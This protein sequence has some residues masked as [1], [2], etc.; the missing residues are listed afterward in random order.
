MYNVPLSSCILAD[1]FFIAGI[2]AGCL[3][4]IAMITLV[5]MVVKSKKAA[6]RSADPSRA[7]LL[8]SKRPLTLNDDDE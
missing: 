2:I 1:L 6:R 3:S 7:P 8:P 4:L 5:V